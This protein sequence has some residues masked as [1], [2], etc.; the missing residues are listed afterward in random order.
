MD[1]EM[2]ELSSWILGDLSPRARVFTA[3]LPALLVSAYFILGYFAYIVRLLLWG[4]AR[5]YETELRG[6][7][8]LL[9]THL[10]FYFFWVINPLWR[11][12]LFTGVS[13]NTVTGFAAAIG[14]GAAA[15]AALGRF[16]LAGWLF[17]FS[18]ILDVMDGR[19][20]RARHEVS[21]AGAAIDSILDR[22][23]DS[24]MLVGLGVYYRDS[25]V[26][27]PVFLALV[28]TSLVPY[29]R[30]KGEALGFPVRDGLMQRTERI[31]YLGGAVA[32]APIFE[33]LVYPLD[34]HP[35]HSLAVAGIIFLC[36]TSNATAVSRFV[37]LV[38]TITAAGATGPRPLEHNKDHAA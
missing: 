17:M 10:R 22:Y 14:V 23:I 25:W 24:L 6:R 31:V 1:F 30:A 16:A 34:R 13:A 3:L 27:I 35:N 29:V 7:T 28:G 4:V 20:A 26:L 5:E 19:L 11:L 38:R 37:R 12:L 8:A 32:L 36:I 2:G 33:A 21:P 18:G 15:A 9:G